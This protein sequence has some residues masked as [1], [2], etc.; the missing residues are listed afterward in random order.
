MGA[1]PPKYY[2]LVKW[3]TTALASIEG[4]NCKIVLNVNGS[5]VDAELITNSTELDT[6]S[7]K[8]KVE[9]R[10]TTRLRIAKNSRGVAMPLTAR[11]FT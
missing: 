4:D 1:P 11:R 7:R 8:V 3:I 5:E 9:K 6:E 2:D 10:T